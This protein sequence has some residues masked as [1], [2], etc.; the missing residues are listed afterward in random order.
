MRPFAFATALI[1]DR[2][3]QEVHARRCRP[4]S[5]LP[6]G[7]QHVAGSPRSAAARV[8]CGCPSAQAGDQR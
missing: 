8:D 2:A 3:H 1:V 4:T 7:A 5:R 6:Q